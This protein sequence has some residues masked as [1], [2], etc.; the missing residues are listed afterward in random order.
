MKTAW[1]KAGMTVDVRAVPSARYL[2]AARPGKGA[3]SF[4]LALSTWI[5]DFA[6]PL[7]FLQMWESDS[8]LNDARFSDPEFDRLLADSA[9]LEGPKRLSALAKAETR[10]LESA[11]CLPLHHSIALNVLDG[12]AVEGWSDNALDIHPFKY[13]GFGQA[14]IRPGV[15]KAEPLA[16]KAQGSVV[17]AALNPA[18]MLGAPEIARIDP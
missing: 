6:Y 15:I 9:A 10:L 11:A 8:N 1:E 5:G 16:P 4:T 2:E 13:L 14:R 7:A 12:D 17:A 3:A 18:D